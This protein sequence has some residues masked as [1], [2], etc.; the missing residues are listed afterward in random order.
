MANK[1]GEY[2]VKQALDVLGEADIV[3]SEMTSDSLAQHALTALNIVR[4]EIR[5][6]NPG[7]GFLKSPY[8]LSVTANTNTYNLNALQSDLLFDN[9]YLDEVAVGTVENNVFTASGKIEYTERQ[10]VLDYLIP[11]QITTTFFYK[12]IG[13]SGEELFALNPKPVQD[14]KLQLIYKEALT[15]DLTS[16]TVQNALE[17]P[18]GDLN[19]MVFGTAYRLAQRLVFPQTRI[20]E[21]ERDYFRARNQSSLLPFLIQQGNRERVAPYVA[22]LIRYGK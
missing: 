3:A 22:K 13:T 20:D 11:N 16:T 5:G 9:I 7:W 4:R 8:I 21:L 17:F 6:I 18:I 10:N 19:M 1:S 2:I 12:D 15:D 14:A